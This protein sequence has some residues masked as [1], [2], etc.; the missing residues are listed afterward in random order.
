MEFPCSLF[1][2]IVIVVCFA[3]RVLRICDGS[4]DGGTGVGHFVLRMFLFCLN[5][6]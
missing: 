5:V 2:R 4:C 3:M 1:L 6:I